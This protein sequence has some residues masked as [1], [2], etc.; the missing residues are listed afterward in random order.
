MRVHT[1]SIQFK[2]DQKLVDLIER[3]LGK[4]TTY[5]DR[6]INAEVVLKL[7]N[8]G[9][10]KDKIIEVRLK[11]PGETLIA[12]ET[13]KTFEASIDKVVASLKRQLIRYKEKIRT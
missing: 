1:E 6:I 5:F 8:S 2:A 12:S 7:E 10:V 4:V 3:K 11:V 13:N 9:Q